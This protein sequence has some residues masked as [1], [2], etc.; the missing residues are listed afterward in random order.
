EMLKWLQRLS[1]RRRFADETAEELQ[2]HLERETESNIDYGM[3][4]VE[5]R[6][7][8]LVGLG[9]LVRARE[10]V[11]E[12]HA[13]YTTVESLSQDLRVACRGFW[14]AKSFAVT[15]VLTLAVGLAGA[16]VM[17]SLIEGVLLRP[18]PVFEQNRL[19]VAWKQVRTSGSAH[20]PFGSEQIKAVA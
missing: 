4:P 16:T 3:S 18:L 20:Y 1:E 17:F 8:A 15:A 7:V 13:P 11:R 9:G 2:F 6:R 5:A 19:L 14:R 12:I 10:E